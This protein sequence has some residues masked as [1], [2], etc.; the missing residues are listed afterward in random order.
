MLIFSNSNCNTPRF[1]MLFFLYVV[2]SFEF[3]PLYSLTSFL[4]SLSFTLLFYSHH[5]LHILSVFSHYCLLLCSHNDLYLCRSHAMFSAI[6]WPYSYYY[7]CFTVPPMH[8]HWHV[9][10]FAWPMA[11][12]SYHT[13]P[14]PMVLPH[15]TVSAKLTV[16]VQHKH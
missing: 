9:E 6:I 11:S 15:L 4:Y 5:Y 12:V 8:I 10:Q 1:P 16:C 14:V 3:S 2:Q 13:V 7:Y